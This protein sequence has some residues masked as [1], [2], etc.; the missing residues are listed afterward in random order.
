VLPQ[1][2]GVRVRLGEPAPQPVSC[3]PAAHRIDER[4]EDRVAGNSGQVVVE[5]EV[6]ADQR[7]VVGARGCVQSR[8]GLVDQPALTA[9]LTRGTIAGAA[10]DVLDPEPAAPDDPLLSMDN[11]LVTPHAQCWTEDFTRDPRPA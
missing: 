9:A 4:R 6:R 5:G 11:V 7:L 1:R 2:A 10:L 8:G 3:R